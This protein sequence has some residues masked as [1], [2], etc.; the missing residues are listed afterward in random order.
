[1]KIANELKTILVCPDCGSGLRHAASETVCVK[2]TRTFPIVSGVP[3]LLPKDSLFSTQGV[4]RSSG[5]YYEDEAVEIEK[6]SLKRRIRAG[7][8]KITKSWERNKFYEAI[9]SAVE[10]VKDPV[11]LQLG[12]GRS[13]NAICDKIPKVNWLN[14]DVDLTFDPDIVADVTGLPFDDESFDI[15]MA[16][17][18]LEHVFDLRKAVEEIQRVTRCGG[19]VA[20]GIPFLYPFHGV[21]YDFTRLTPSGLRAAFAQTDKVFFSRDSGSF[22]ALALMLE[23]RFVNIFRSRSLR[24][25]TTFAVRPFLSVFKHLDRFS[26]ATRQLSSAASLLYVGRKSATPHTS[27]ELIAELR[28]DFAH[29]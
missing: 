22:V 9:N 21:P 10:G 6:N 16:D 4:E 17:N 26:I 13:P 24:G 1:M 14:S 19:I 23:G 27:L 28:A 3:I 15:V 12:S 20:I 25:A 8:P 7:L 2:C 18:V 29:L 11:G 5:T